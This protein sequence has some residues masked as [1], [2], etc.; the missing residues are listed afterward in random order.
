MDRRLARNRPI[1][2]G[3]LYIDRGIKIIVFLITF[4]DQ[5]VPC[6][7][8][9]RSDGGILRRSPGCIGCISN[10][11]RLPVGTYH[12]IFAG[13]QIGEASGAALAVLATAND[14]LR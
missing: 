4:G 3:I 13:D 1:N 12:A 2:C 9:R 6:R 8:C 14:V 10:N 11:L 7:I 5:Y